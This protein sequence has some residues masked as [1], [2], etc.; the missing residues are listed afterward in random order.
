LREN[1]L[2]EVKKKDLKK[3]LIVQVKHPAFNIEQEYKI[4]GFNYSRHLNMDN[5]VILKQFLVKKPYK[6]F[7]KENNT[8]FFYSKKELVRTRF[9]S[10][11]I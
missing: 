10:L 9:K 3:G 1:Y 8:K 7:V 4:H 6:F 2:V 5:F 11:E